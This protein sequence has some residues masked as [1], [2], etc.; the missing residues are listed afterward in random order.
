MKLPAGMLTNCMRLTFAMLKYCGSEIALDH[1]GIRFRREFTP[2]Q[3]QFTPVVIR[4]GW[5]TL[6][7]LM[8]RSETAVE[9]GSVLRL[10]LSTVT[11]KVRLAQKLVDCFRV[12]RH[13]GANQV[14]DQSFQYVCKFFR[15]LIRDLLK[16]WE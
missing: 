12:A 8:C 3:L 6:P 7:G 1:H 11:W 5:K 16:H 10:L 14:L 4:K 13:S 2:N 15:L 9:V